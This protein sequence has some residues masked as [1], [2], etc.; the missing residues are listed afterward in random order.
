MEWEAFL[1]SLRLSAWTTGILFVI[2]LLMA[3]A[4]AWRT[5]PGKGLV[6]AVVALPLVL[7]PTVLGYYLLV[8]LG[9]GSPLG[10]AYEQLTGHS[11]V[12][13]FSG[14]LLAS[15]IY[16][17]PFAVQ[18]M[19]RGFESVPRA[20]REA[21][22]CSG[23]GHVATFT[24]IELPLAWPGVLSGLVLAFAHTMGEFGVVLMVGGNIP[25][26]TRT[27]AIAIYDRTQAFDPQAAGTMSLVLLGFAFITVGLVYTLSHRR[28]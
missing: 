18:P 27:I 22:W 2:G 7:P 8:A 12:F 20:L 28:A 23:L 17:L 11:L 1:L 10:A 26:Q 6:E 9:R 15:V 19:L 21:A 13:S 25:G 4:L 14:L 24:R 3:R 5:F 16:S